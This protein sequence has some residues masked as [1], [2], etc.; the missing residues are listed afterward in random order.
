MTT[1]PTRMTIDARD[2]GLHGN[3]LLRLDMPLRE[4]AAGL[5]RPRPLLYCG[6]LDPRRLDYRPPASLVELAALSR[7]IL[8][9]GFRAALVGPR[10]LGV[11]DEKLAALGVKDPADQ[12]SDGALVGAVLGHA[13]L[14]HA[15]EGNSA[16]TPV[17]EDDLAPLKTAVGVPAQVGRAIDEL[18]KRARAYAPLPG[19]PTADD[20]E[21]KTR[22]YAAQVMDAVASEL[23]VLHDHPERRFLATVW[24][25]E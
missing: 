2:S 19:A 3:G 7:A 9:I 13:L 14:G 18:A 22:A 24:S 15:P 17:A 21:A 8:E 12:P 11:T 6:L 16:V 4:V 5:L 25:R 20:V 1:S 10:G 23:L